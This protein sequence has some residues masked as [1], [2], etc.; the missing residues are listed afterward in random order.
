MKSSPAPPCGER[1]EG[2]VERLASSWRRRATSARRGRGSRPRTSL[3]ALRGPAS[4]RTARAAYGSD[5]PERITR[6]VHLAPATRPCRRSRPPPGRRPPQPPARPPTRQP[7]SG[8]GRSRAWCV[9]GGGALGFARYSDSLEKPLRRDGHVGMARP[10]PARE[11]PAPPTSAPGRRPRVPQTEVE[12]V[13]DARVGGRLGLVV[14]IAHPYGGRARRDVER[15]HHV[16]AL[17]RGVELAGDHAVRAGAMGRRAPAHVA[18][19]LR[20][21]AR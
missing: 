17:E 7:G 3:P 9:P 1:A 13:L 2:V 15:K 14:A 5:L 21:A 16:R 6:H 18:R 10:S 20:P 19:A 12:H 4:R 11:T 8:P